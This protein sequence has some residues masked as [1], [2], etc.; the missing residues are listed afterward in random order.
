MVSCDEFDEMEPGYGH[1]C[2]TERNRTNIR[3]QVGLCVYV[4]LPGDCRKTPESDEIVFGTR[5][6]ELKR[7]VAS[8]FGGLRLAAIESAA[9][10]RPRATAQRPNRTWASQRRRT[11]SPA[12]R[13]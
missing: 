11:V 7:T 10:R 4:Q 2:F 3:I 6:A 5:P 13:G 9:D 12:H 8:E 1:R